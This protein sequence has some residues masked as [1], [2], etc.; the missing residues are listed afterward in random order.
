MPGSYRARYSVERILVDRTSVDGEDQFDWELALVQSEKGLLLLVATLF[1]TNERAVGQ[2]LSLA[3]LAPTQLGALSDDAAQRAAR[4][5]IRPLY[6]TARRALAAQG[7]L[8]DVDFALPPVP[9]K[10]EI[11]LLRDD[12]EESSSKD[13]RTHS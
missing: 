12:D 9:P 7:A 10:A 2:V 6:D 11:T 4:R 5:H 13:Q 3:R 8:M 1:R